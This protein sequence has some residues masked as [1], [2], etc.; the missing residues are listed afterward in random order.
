MQTA[1]YKGART[2]DK[3]SAI[4]IVRNQKSIEK[5]MRKNILFQT[6]QFRK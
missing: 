6:C 3:I 1:G 5:V 4:K 2:V